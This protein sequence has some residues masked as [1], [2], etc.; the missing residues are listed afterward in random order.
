MRVLTQLW[1][2]PYSKFREARNCMQAAIFKYL[3][4]VPSVCILL[5]NNWHGI[6]SLCAYRII[7]AMMFG[8]QGYG[9]FDL[10]TQSSHDLLS[11]AHAPSPSCGRASRRARNMMN[12]RFLVSWPCRL[13]A[14]CLRLDHLLF[15]LL[16]LLTTTSSHNSLG[17]LARF[18]GGRIHW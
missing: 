8:G 16:R 5:R 12:C 3:P 18:S 9:A 2:D 14:I 15:P 4:R 7:Q 10:A 13:M 1:N 11:S 17:K 6:D